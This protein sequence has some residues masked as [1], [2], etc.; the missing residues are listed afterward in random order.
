MQFME[1][2]GGIPYI[3]GDRFKDRYIDENTGFETRYYYQIV[4]VDGGGINY[5]N[6]PFSDISKHIPHIIITNPVNP[7]FLDDD[8][9]ITD[10]RGDGHIRTLVFK[11]EADTINSVEYQIDG[12]SWNSMLAYDGSAIL[13]ES[14]RVSGPVLPNDGKSHLVRVR[15]NMGG[16]DYY[17]DS[18][19]VTNQPERK[20]FFQ[21]IIFWILLSFGGIAVF[22]NRDNLPLKRRDGKNRRLTHKEKVKKRITHN[23]EM[24]RP[25]WLPYLGWAFFLCFLFV[26]WGIFPINQGQPIAVYSFY[27]FYPM[28]FN[29]LLE[30]LIYTAPRLLLVLPCMYWGIRTY[31]PDV[32]QF[33]AFLMFCGVGVMA[34]VGWRGFALNGLFLPGAYF[35]LV[36]SV[37]ILVGN[38]KNTFL[39]RLRRRK[40]SKM[41]D[42]LIEVGK[43]KKK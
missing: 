7:L 36:I 21:T 12:G 17:Y 13:F 19:V 25:W 35:E 18:A 2:W 5:L 23:K 6:L 10:T 11:N 16:S 27:C 33:G 15:V 32:V 39:F 8:D 3:M 31:H 42:S 26:P 30:S 29:F 24:N 38:L 28:G 22:I 14:S 1:T 20:P 4:S 40:L 9:L 41:R 37:L 34:Y 43:K